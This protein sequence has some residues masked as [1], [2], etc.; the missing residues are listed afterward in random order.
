MNNLRSLLSHHGPIPN[1][2]YR[3]YAFKSD[4]KIKWVRPEKIPCYKPAKSGDLESF[5]GIDK[6]QPIL[7][8]RDSKELETADDNVKKLFSL[9]FAPQKYTHRVYFHEFVDKVKRHEY[10]IASIEVKIA[11]WTGVIRAFQECM[12][13]FPRNKRLKV[14]LKE[15]IDKRKKHLKY[16]RRW[17]YKRFEWLLETI[18]MV[19]KPP[20]NEF[21]WITRKDS[22]RK[23][24]DQH[25]E[26]IRS[27]RL[28]Q[29][30]QQ[31]ENEQP[32]FLEEKI[33]TLQFIREE[34]KECGAEVTVTEEEIDNCRK[35]LDELK[36]KK[37][38]DKDKKY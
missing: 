21:H 25:C 38:D 16:L 33:R 13:R 22:L 18:N 30:K 7:D 14:S 5:P 4:L 3:H 24:T 8:F 36:L 12:E 15:L 34:Q 29:Y 19:Y 37:K 1:T 6:K 35:L 11:K 31:L 23:L 17:D 10:D 28:N 2:L 20:P 32:A 27:E 9:E 26:K